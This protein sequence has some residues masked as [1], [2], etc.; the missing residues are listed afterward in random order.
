MKS[1][2]D[3]ITG[4]ILQGAELDVDVPEKRMRWGRRVGYT[5]EQIR[6]MWWADKRSPKVVM[7]NRN[8]FMR[9]EG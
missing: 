1:F 6:R 7:V 9:A 5:D 2:T 3:P 4:C 8:A